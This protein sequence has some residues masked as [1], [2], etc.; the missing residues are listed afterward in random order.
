MKLD[1]VQMVNKIVVQNLYFSFLHVYVVFI[2]CICLILIDCSYEPEIQADGRNS[3]S[4][5]EVD[6]NTGKIVIVTS[7][8]Y[9]TAQCKM[10]KYKTT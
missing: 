3:K 4:E 1:C 5:R 2:A 8:Y 7:T 6:E 9:K 10:F